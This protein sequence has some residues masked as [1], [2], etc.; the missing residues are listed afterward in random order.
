MESRCWGILYTRW[1]RGKHTGLFTSCPGTAFRN[2][3]LKERQKER[4]KW[5][6]KE[7]EKGEEEE[8]EEEEG[9]GGEEE[10]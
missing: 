9:G 10:E 6:E 3:L 2:K 4:G 1:E 5:L 8:K 7:E